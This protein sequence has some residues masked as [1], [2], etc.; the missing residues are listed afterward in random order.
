LVRSTTIVCCCPAAPVEPPKAIFSPPGWQLLDASADG[1][2]CADGVADEPAPP[3][4]VPPEDVPPAGALAPAEV[5][6][7]VPSV[8][9]GAVLELWDEQPATVSPAQTQAA[10]PMS[11]R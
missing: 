1:V 8:I 10:T 11:E 9:P 4:A 6:T 7:G 5:A 2:N 3:D